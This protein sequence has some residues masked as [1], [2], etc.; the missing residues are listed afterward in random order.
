[1]T[2][3]DSTELTPVATPLLRLSRPVAACSRCRV[4]KIKCD[5]KSPACTPCERANKADE[6]S[7]TNEQFA[8]GKD[9]GWIEH[10]FVAALESRV[11]HLQE[12]V[13]EK[14]ESML[15]RGMIP[16]VLALEANDDKGS[17]SNDHTSPEIGIIARLFQSCTYVLTEI[18]REQRRA[19]VL[20]K[21]CVASLRRSVQSLIQ[22]G[23]SHDV[24]GGILDSRLQKSR[25]LRDTTLDILRN[26]GLL[27][28]KGK[29]WLRV[30]GLNW[31]K[32]PRYA[33][34][35]PRLRKDS[36]YYQGY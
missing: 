25:R 9:R 22:W 1:M 4:A 24:M 18:V 28:T 23:D 27:A 30:D 7:R 15:S 12:K 26:I 14:R 8:K 20:S 2:S 32:N 35:G 13:N 6:C 3:T 5:G 11:K 16:G 17:P 31:L 36:Q 10:D 33:I 34:S 19:T 21:P 29:L